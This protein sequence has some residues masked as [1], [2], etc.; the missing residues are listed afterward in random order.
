MFSKKTN[1]FDLFVRVQAYTQCF[2]VISKLHCNI[3]FV[4]L[5]E[6]PTGH[7][8]FEINVSVI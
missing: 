1:A 3:T 2:L 8:D 4:C 6:N 5:Q 7:P